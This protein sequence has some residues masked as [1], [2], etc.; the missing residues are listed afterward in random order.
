[1]RARISAV[2]FDPAVL[3]FAVS[4][5]VFIAMVA[6]TAK[7]S[8]GKV[9][10]EPQDPSTAESFTCTGGGKD[11]FGR[12][13]GGG[14]VV[15]E[16]NPEQGILNFTFSGGQGE[17]NFSGDERTEPHNFGAHVTFTVN[18]AGE[19]TGTYSGASGPRGTQGG[20]HC[21][22]GGTLEEPTQECVGSEGYQPL[23]P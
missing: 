14:R 20:G 11:T 4:V 16:L 22:F 21:T 17:G 3:F 9:N 10:C 2:L 7:P 12:G 19:I 5:V 1:M 6:L 8:S 15:Q 23:R 13:G 18:T